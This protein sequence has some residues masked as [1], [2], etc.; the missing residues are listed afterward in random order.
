MAFR[1]RRGKKKVCLKIS[2]PRLLVAWQ[3]EAQTPQPLCPLASACLSVTPPS[4]S[5]PHRLQAPTHYSWISKYS[6]WSF[7]PPSPWKCSS[8]RLKCPP[9]PPSSAWWIPTYFSMIHLKTP[10]LWS[11]P[12]DSPPRKK[13]LPLLRFPSTCCLS[14]LWSKILRTESTLTIP[15]SCPWATPGKS[16][17]FPFSHWNSSPR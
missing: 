2:L 15:P 1:I 8:P 9:W 5:S 17:S 14:L 10:V 16:D 6:V 7:M 12:V 3:D 11:P 13:Q 4:H